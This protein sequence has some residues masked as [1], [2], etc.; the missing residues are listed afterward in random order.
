MVSVSLFGSE[1]LHDAIVNS[2]G[3]FSK[4]VEGIRSLARVRGSRFFPRIS[5]RTI[6]LPDNFDFLPEMPALAHELGADELVLS[7]ESTSKTAMDAKA[8]SFMQ[9]S[10]SMPT[11][12]D[13]QALRKSLEQTMSSSAVPV[14]INP[15]CSIEQTVDAYRGHFING[16]FDC[17]FP[18]T[19][20]IITPV[21]D[22]GLCPHVWVGNLHQAGWREMWNGPRALAFRRSMMECSELP[23]FCAGCC[24]KISRQ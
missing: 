1:S 21:G 18:W 6:I 14:S 10:Q 5:L 4:A 8:E 13:A 23:S 16:A 20:M 24:S 3:A 11:P 15:R 2:P 12:I 17:L 22:I 9:T 19:K 7:H